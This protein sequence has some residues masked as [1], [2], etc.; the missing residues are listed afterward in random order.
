[1]ACGTS[2][3]CITTQH[4]TDITN[5]LI[6][7]SRASAHIQHTH[8]IQTSHTNTRSHDPISTHITYI[9]H[10]HIAHITHITHMTS[11]T[12][13][14]LL[15]C[16]C[17]CV[18]RVCGCVWLC[19]CVCVAVLLCAACLCVSSAFVCLVVFV[20]VCVD[21]ASDPRCHTSPLLTCTDTGANHE[22]TDIASHHIAPH[23]TYHTHGQ[24]THLAWNGVMCMGVHHTHYAYHPNT[25]KHNHITIS[26][27]HA[28]DFKA[29]VATCVRLFLPL[30]LSVHI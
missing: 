4:I 14:G 6:I 16:L 18:R 21:A 23:D 29:C 3:T 2:H 13:S 17:W 26:V 15:L 11:N 5:I 7:I 27:T 19:L 10:T 30:L 25:I 28:V 8:R 12:L 20:C 9:T 22:D 1:M 24:L